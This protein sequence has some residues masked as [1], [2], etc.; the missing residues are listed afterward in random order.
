MYLKSKLFIINKDCNNIF[1]FFNPNILLRRSYPYD[2]RI[3]NFGNTGVGGRIHT[4]LAHT[5]TRL[6][7]HCVYDYFD[8]R[9]SLIKLGFDENILIENHLH[10]WDKFLK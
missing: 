3:H 5:F 4:E 2:P 6:I 9:K 8:I 7:D 10:R 1:G